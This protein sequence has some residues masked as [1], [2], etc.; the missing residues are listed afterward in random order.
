MVNSYL[1]LS[2]MSRRFDRK[3]LLAMTAEAAENKRLSREFLGAHAFSYRRIPKH[4]TEVYLKDQI[5]HAGE[6]K[7]LRWFAVKFGK[8]A[9]PELE[10]TP[11][12]EGAFLE[13]LL[14][15]PAEIRLGK[16][17]AVYTKN[18]NIYKIAITEKGILSV[19]ER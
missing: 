9:L 2:L 1:M 17:K 3:K 7:A 4:W 15:H 11:L 6:P 12:A 8:T 10:V 19:R 16:K 5:R 13:L 18:G 14:P